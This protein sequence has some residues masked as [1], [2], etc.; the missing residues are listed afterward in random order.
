[1]GS[2]YSTE[3]PADGTLPNV[4]GQEYGFRVHRVEPNSPG[5][6]AGLQ[7]IVDYIVV[8]NGVRLDHDDGSFVRMIAES[9]DTPMRLCVFDTHTLRT[10][11]TVLTPSDAWGGS[12]LLGITIRFD[13]VQPLSKHT[14]HVLEVFP[15]SPASAAE[16]DG[17]NDYVLGVGDLLYDGP[18]EFGEIVL[19]NERR[20][21][22]LYVYSVRT[23]EVREVLITPDRGWGGDGVLGCG[24]GAGYL[25]TLPPRRDLRKGQSAAAPAQSAA[26]PAEKPQP[27]AV[28]QEAPPNA[29]PPSA[30]VSVPPSQPP[31]KPPPGPP[32]PGPPPPGPPPPGVPLPYNASRPEGP[33]PLAPAPPPGYSYVQTP[34]PYQPLPL[35]V[36][37]PPG[38]LSPNGSA[39]LQD[40]SALFGGAP[41][42]DSEF[43]EVRLT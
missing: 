9:K 4:V 28:T 29:A 42:A 41:P 33:P 12:G 20:P 34:R 11:E 15:D 8:A 18:D 31:P 23:E 1:M 16:L 26:A 38:A 3:A 35:G 17:F 14:L 7:S 6:A 30:A 21:V 10:R 24:V 27:R 40:A 22:R 13:I 37:P 36:A 32:P 43:P 5:S 25:H 39:P 19:H 2:S